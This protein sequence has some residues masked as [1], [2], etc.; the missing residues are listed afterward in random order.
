MD[1]FKQNR[2]KIQVEKFKNQGVVLQIEHGIVS[3]IVLAE[4][5]RNK[6][7]V[8]EMCTKIGMKICYKIPVDK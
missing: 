4:L 5:T 2:Q 1:F 8:C 7:H 6:I 3:E